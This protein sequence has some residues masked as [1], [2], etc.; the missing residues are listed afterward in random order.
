MP[1]TRATDNAYEIGNRIRS[2][3]AKAA[4]EGLE[5]LKTRNR[6]REH[7]SQP[8]QPYYLCPNGEF[9]W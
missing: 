1:V 2:R 5:L 6:V 9:P 4:Q 8:N 7:N 3:Q